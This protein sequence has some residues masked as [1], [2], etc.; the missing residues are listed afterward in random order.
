MA[1]NRAAQVTVAEPVAGLRWPA[2]WW[3]IGWALVLAVIV[4]TLIPPDDYHTIV[5]VDLNDKVAHVIVYTT[6]AGWFGCLSLGRRLLAPTLMLLGM[7]AV[8]ELAQ[9]SSIYRMFDVYDLL[10]NWLGVAVGT[11]LMATPLRRGLAWSEQ[12][13]LNP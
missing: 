1:A 13:L 5:R 7:G 2:L 11:A 12:R 3:C 8:L 6:L 9:L 10:A 4:L